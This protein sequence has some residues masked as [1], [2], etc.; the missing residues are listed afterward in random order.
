[1]LAFIRNL[2]VRIY[3][4]IATEFIRVKLLRNYPNCRLHE[5]VVVD[6]LSRL[7][8]FNVLFEGARLINSTLGD[9]TYLQICATAQACDVGKYCSIAMNAYLG[10]P[11]HQ[12]S[13]VSSHPIFYYKNTPLLKTFC[14]SDLMGTHR[15]TTI[16]HDVWIGHGAMVMSGLNIGTGAVIG[17]GAVVTQDIPAYAIAV[18]V[19]ARVIRYRFDEALRDR[20]L[21]SR[22][23][24]MPDTWLETYN[25]L[26][27]EPLKLLAAM[28][29]TKNVH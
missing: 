15:R 22:W 10:L 18:G 3:S 11:Q 20:L 4:E 12:F 21:A 26:F 16:G 23:W 6:P 19:P 17:A 5:G 7:S 2:Y 24:E 13:G 29:S 8:R 14:K 27:A 28:D 9:H 25:D 1:M